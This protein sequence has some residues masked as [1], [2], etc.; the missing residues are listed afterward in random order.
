MVAK[1]DWNGASVPQYR[2]FGILCGK[3]V[4]RCGGVIRRGQHLYLPNYT[5]ALVWYLSPSSVLG[6]FPGLQERKDYLPVSSCQARAQG[7][8]P[9]YVAHEPHLLPS[10]IPSIWVH[11]H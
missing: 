10:W 4:L 5:P 9:S 2:F 7:C 8:K 1:Y 6:K 3:Y 11:V